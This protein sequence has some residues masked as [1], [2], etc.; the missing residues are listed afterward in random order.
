MLADKTLTCRECGADFIFS[1]GEQEFYAEKGLTNE[2]QR[3]ASCRG[4]RR[5]QR[6]AGQEAREMH[7]VVCAECGG[8][9]LVPFLPRNDKPVY[10]S[11]CFAG[12]QPVGSRY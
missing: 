10:C 1:V 7:E 6:A 5:R 12:R 3:C 4:L 8:P 11:N 9:A 2:P